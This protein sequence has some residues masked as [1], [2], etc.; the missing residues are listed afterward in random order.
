MTPPP[1]SHYADGGGVTYHYHDLGSGPDTVFLHGGGPGCT[2]WSDFGPVAP[3]FAEDR[4]GPPL[5]NPHHR[6]PAE[7]PPPPA[8]WGPPPAQTPAPPGTPASA[9]W[10]RCRPRPAASGRT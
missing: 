7:N 6:P 1:E 8:E 3:L 9:S 5:G 10:P 2:G 4:R